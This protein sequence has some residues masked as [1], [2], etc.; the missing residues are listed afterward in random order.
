MERVLYSCTVLVHVSDDF[1][2]PLFISR[3]NWEKKKRWRPN[4]LCSLICFAWKSP[5][6]FWRRKSLKTLIAPFIIIC[7]FSFSTCYWENWGNLY[8]LRKIKGSFSLGLSN[9]TTKSYTFYLPMIFRSPHYL[10][11]YPFLISHFPKVSCFSF[12]YPISQTVPD[13]LNFTKNQLLNL[14]FDWYKFVHFIFH[15]Y[16]FWLTLLCLLLHF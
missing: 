4:Q 12:V 16:L 15:F 2:I 14:F 5:G 3:S 8:V 6:A 10:L 7:L 1:Y 9:L 11:L 13:S